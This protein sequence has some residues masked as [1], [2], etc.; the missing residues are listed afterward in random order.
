MHL[1]FEVRT[2]ALLALFLSVV[3]I[4][5]SVRAG[6]EDSVQVA[7]STEIEV[8]KADIRFLQHASFRKADA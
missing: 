8:N 6:N 2:V 4:S 7:M 3:L 1:R 5:F